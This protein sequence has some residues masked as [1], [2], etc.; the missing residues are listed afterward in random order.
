VNVKARFYSIEFLRTEPMP[1]IA[2]GFLSPGASIAGRPGTVATVGRFTLFFYLKTISADEM[3]GE[4]RITPEHVLIS[5]AC[6]I[7]HRRRLSI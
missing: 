3:P 4:K 6:P 2:F 1:D 5:T 7:W